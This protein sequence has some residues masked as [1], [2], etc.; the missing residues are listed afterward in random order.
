MFNANDSSMNGTC[1]TYSIQHERN[2]LNCKKYH[3][4]FFLFYITKLAKTKTALA[5][6][7][8]Q[9]KFCVSYQALLPAVWLQNYFNAIKVM[10]GQ[11]I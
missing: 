2:E 10:V 8:M 4:Q 11:V 1:N 6:C 9:L 7:S 3:D 5:V